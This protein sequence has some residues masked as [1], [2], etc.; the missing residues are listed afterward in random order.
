VF[1][2]VQGNKIA[3]DAILD[4]PDIAAVSFVGST[5]IAKY[6]HERATASGKRVQALGGAKNHAIVLPD[7]DLEFAANHLTAAAFGSAGQ[8]CMAISVGIAVGEAGDALVD[9]LTRKAD[10]VKVGPGN[11]I[12]SDMGPVVTAAARD[13]VIN[14]V[15]AGQKQGA[16]VVVDGRGLT[17]AGH[18][19][20]FFVGPCWPSP[21]AAAAASSRPAPP[22]TRPA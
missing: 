14:S 18:E 2:V 7:A 6:V 19:N 21:D 20:G 4:H 1:N 10:E 15:S 22:P 3:V 5:P 11:D 12:S 17:V 9:V 8:R 13:R 16:T